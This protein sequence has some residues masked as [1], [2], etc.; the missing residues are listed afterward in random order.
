[1]RRGLRQSFPDLGPP[2]E[3]GPLTS[4][5]EI[6]MSRSNSLRNASLTLALACGFAG[7]LAA[8]DAQTQ[9]WENTVT[10]YGWAAAM[11][12]TEAIGPI[13][14]T[15][16]VPFSDIMDNLKMG[17]MLNYVGRGK[18]WVTGADFIYMKLGSDLAVP[19]T[20]T[21]VAEVK[22]KQWLFEVD[23][24]YRVL[25]WLDA[26]IGVRVP[27][28]EAEFVPNTDNPN[29]SAKSQS[30]SWFA[31]LIGARAIVPLSKHFTVIARGDLGGFQIGGTNT[32]WQAAGY[33]NYKFG[34]H[35]SGDLGYRAINA[36]Y[37]TGTKG[38]QGYF[39]YDITNFGGL[40]GISYTF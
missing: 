16:D 35:F 37:A 4:I 36:D 22:V 1:M 14:M 39:Q 5:P 28:I 8:Q 10:L 23:G 19:S 9:K 3:P 29:F 27:V 24:G 30:E 15:V 31:P 11:S 25:P 12:G 20:G 13:S 18:T 2:W 6:L 21:T 38:Q 26:L 40:L 32:T 33:V 17:A 7:T 34:K